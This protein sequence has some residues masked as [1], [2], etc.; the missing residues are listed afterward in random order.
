MAKP[1]RFGI[2]IDPDITKE[3]VKEIERVAKKSFREDLLKKLAKSQKE[4]LD[5]V[6]EAAIQSISD[7]GTKVIIDPETPASDF[8]VYNEPAGARRFSDLTGESAK[9][10]RYRVA[11]QRGA[12]GRFSTSLTLTWGPVI[13]DVGFVHNRVKRAEGGIEGTGKKLVRKRQLSGSEDKVRMLEEG[14]TF[15]QVSKSPFVDLE[16]VTH[17]RGFYPLEGFVKHNQDPVTEAFFNE[18]NKNIFDVLDKLEEQFRAS[19]SSKSVKKPSRGRT[20]I[21][22]T[23]KK[24]G[25][26]TK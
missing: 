11:A 15:H 26:G 6:G 19:K 2:S 7:G 9:A 16:G 14:S 1:K 3:A 21:K 12:I 22:G 10:I 17:A 5:N 24:A 13:V 25:M 18:V 20:T 4:I 8:R 23:Q